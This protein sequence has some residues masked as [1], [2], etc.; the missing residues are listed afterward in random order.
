[1]GRLELAKGNYAAAVALLEASRKGDSPEESSSLFGA[2]GSAYIGLN[3]WS[4]A[5]EA[6]QTAL[7]RQRR[8]TEWRMRYGDV[9]VK[10]GKTNEAEH[11]YREVLALEPNAAEAWKKLGELKKK[12]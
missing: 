5:A 9:L 11:Q 12:Y 8:N 6:L 7:S 10:L 3:R 1:L 4:E 2:L